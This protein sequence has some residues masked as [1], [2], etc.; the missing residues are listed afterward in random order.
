MAPDPN[1][2][3][4]SFAFLERIDRGE[5]TGYTSPTV[6]N[7]A[8]H[9]LMMVEACTTF[10]WPTAGIANRLRRHQGEISKLQ[11]FRR[12]INIVAKSKLITLAMDIQD[13]L[14][15][16]ELS[17]RHGLFSGDALILAVMQR[18][19]LTNIA[20]HDADFDRVPQL[21]RFAAG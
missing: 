13:A 20:S 8:A 2:G 15:A 10:G 18:H 12:A 19:N 1:L 5:I 6:L 3:P 14:L 7:D 9:R 21:A 17:I 11:S 16:A 4:S